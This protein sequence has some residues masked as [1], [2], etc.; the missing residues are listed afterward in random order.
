MRYVSINTVP[1]GS[2]G[3][4]MRQVTEE[5]RELGDE[6]WC[7]WGRGR[8]AENDHEY[9]FGTTAGTY[10]DAL[11]TRIDGRAG[12]HSKRATKRLLA[13]LDEIRPDIVHLH[14]I[15][16]YYVNVEMLFEWLAAHED[17]QVKW[18]LH[19]C[20]AFTGHC[21][22]FT[23]VGC[24]QWRNGS[25]CVKGCPQLDTYPK[26]MCASSSGWSYRRKQACFTQLSPG[27]MTLI[28]PSHWLE[29]L[30]KESFLAKYP[31]EVRHN[32]I[33]R[34][35]FKPTPSDFRQRYGIGNRFMILGVA[36]P[37]NER[38]GLSVFTGLARELE[39]DK[40][41]IVLVG[42]SRRQI[43]QL[44]RV[45]VALP[46]TDNTRELAAAYTASNVYIQPSSEETFGMTV[47]EAVACGTPVIVT[48]GSAC[49]EAAVGGTVLP[50]PSDMS[51][52][53]STVVNLAEVFSN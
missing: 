21:A 2:T 1:N 50:V 19:D 5:R 26:T 46:R 27:R 48:E 8:A 43:K 18:T 9:N 36:S 24:D 13:K 17:V 31:V 12:F 49:V 15:H 25:G 47:A 53:I 33:D 38:K 20:W 16:G 37:W 40:Y 29:G 32:T 22:Y 23:Y 10:L 11:Q 14:N 4:V 41:V 45:I 30:V 28:T 42:L 35:V 6:C 3:A 52:L 51:S 44:S 39:S 7:M 34:S